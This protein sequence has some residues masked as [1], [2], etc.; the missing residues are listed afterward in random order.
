MEEVYSYTISRLLDNISSAQAKVRED[1]SLSLRH[2]DTLQEITQQLYELYPTSE[3]LEKVSVASQGAGE[4]RASA[5]QTNLAK[6]ITAEKKAGTETYRLQVRL[7][8]SM[9]KF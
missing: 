3:Y 6:S 2:L 5:T 8:E 9:D 7:F 4:T 1:P